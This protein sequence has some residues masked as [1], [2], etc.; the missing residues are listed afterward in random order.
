[1]EDT[2][3][4]CRGKK[5]ENIKPIKVLLVEDNSG[6]ARLIGEMLDSPG[7]HIFSLK[8]VNSLSK[9]LRSLFPDD[10][11]I[12][13]LDL[14]LPDSHGLETFNR[15]YS[16]APGVPIVILS[17][18]DDESMAIRAV[19][20]GAQD[21]LVKG[22]ID[23]GLL[24]RAIHYAIERKNAERELHGAYQKLKT[25]QEQ[26]I[27]AGKMAAMGQ[28]AAGISHELNQPL[29]G[30]KGFAQTALM[31][32]EANSPL[33]D[34]LNK[35]V[36]QADRMDRIIRHVRFFARKSD[37]HLRE[38][39]MNGPVNDALMLLSEQLKVHNIR[40]KKSLSGDLPGVLGDPNQLE[41]VFLN[42][43]TNARDAIDILQ[44][45]EGGEIKIKSGTSGDRKHIELT[46][47]DT[48]CGISEKALEHI[49]NPFFTTKSPDGGMG[50]GLSIVYRIIENHKGRIEVKS[51]TGRG[52]MFRIF[53]PVYK[54]VAPLNSAPAVLC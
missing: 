15:L 45:P 16:R 47:E 41:Q 33:R 4:A 51:R 32:L 50:L 14:S 31:D 9:G 29:T 12:V 8:R 35:I 40:V 39:D 42:L 26:L 36:E 7:S 5:M 48:G 34:D 43:I 53:L 17:G 25:A 30:I 20:E 21:Y 11:D 52:T 13:L 19:H 3:V 10:I 28:L 2:T 22:R 24:I 54:E 23:S 27:Q 44:R 37:F 1:M 49:F 6:D 46:F 38:M 18:Q